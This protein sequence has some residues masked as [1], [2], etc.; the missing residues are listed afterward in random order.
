[1][2]AKAFVDHLTSLPSSNAPRRTAREVLEW[3]DVR[4]AS[5]GA[6]AATTIFT[7]PW[8]Q[9]GKDAGLSAHQTPEVAEVFDFMREA[10]E[11]IAELSPQ[12]IVSILSCTLPLR[13]HQERAVLVV[14]A[15]RQLLALG[16]DRLE[17]IM[18]GLR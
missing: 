5:A 1:M 8:E 17:D 6:D 3:I 13:A 10:A 16:E 18:R 7:K 4:L 2:N 12:A 14:A 15:E 9:A 11:R